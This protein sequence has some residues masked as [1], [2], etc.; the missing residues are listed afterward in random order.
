MIKNEKIFNKK[1]KKAEN[2]V[3]RHNNLVTALKKK[4]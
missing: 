4:K 2:N 1:Y 3:Q